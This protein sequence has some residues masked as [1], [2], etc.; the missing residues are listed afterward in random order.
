M[1]KL[2]RYDIYAPIIQTEQ[3]YSFREAAALVLQSFHAFDPKIGR[4]AQRVFDEKHYDGEIRTGK[5]GTPFCATPIPELTPWIMHNF[6]GQLVD[7]TIM[8]HEL[9]HAI[10]SM[11]AAHLPKLTHFSSLPLAETAS[12]FSQL[13]L[14]DYLLARDPTPE[15]QQ[16]LTFNQLDESF[17]SILRQGYFALFERA[18]YEA[19][20]DGAGVDDLCALYLENLADQFGDAVTMSD[21]FQYEWL[22]IPHFYQWPF[23]VYA[24]SFGHLLV[25]SLY[26]QYQEE[27]DPF[28]ARYL[29]ILTA[30]GSAA[31]VQILAEA[32]IDIYKAEF[33]QGGF[34]LLAKQVEQ[35]E[36]LIDQPTLAAS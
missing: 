27:G 20:Q 15:Q 23:Y 32:G 29:N 18:A 33:W 8:A 22:S 26:D 11:L 12:I 6:T 13:L 34:D 35:L 16:V 25:L 30:G 5:E 14:M 1:D 4:L 24:Y 2:R 19:I 31:P 3:S 36:N 9:G 21:G 10:H 17:L 7:V 28:K